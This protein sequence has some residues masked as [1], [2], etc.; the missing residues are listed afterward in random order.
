MPYFSGIGT[1]EKQF[2]G[3]SYEP[4]ALAVAFLDATKAMHSLA[5]RAGNGKLMIDDPLADEPDGAGMMTHRESALLRL[6]ALR[7]LC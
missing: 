6:F 1:V 3:F 2:P 7:H 4:E 5:L